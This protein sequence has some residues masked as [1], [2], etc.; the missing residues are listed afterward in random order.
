MSQIP[1]NLTGCLGETAL[2]IISGVG[3]LWEKSCLD[4]PS[5]SQVSISGLEVNHVLAPQKVMIQKTKN[6]LNKIPNNPGPE[7]TIKPFYVPQGTPHRK[8]VQISY[9]S[10]PYFLAPTPS[11][12]HYRRVVKDL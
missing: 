1:L 10:Q 3:N 12:L 2:W 6:Q 9:K 7:A 4:G 8:R 5:V 11:L